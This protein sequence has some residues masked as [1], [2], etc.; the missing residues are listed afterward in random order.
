MQ[1]LEQ[2]RL[3]NITLYYREGTSDKV[4]QCSIEPAGERFVVNFAYG[5]RNS[6]LNTG[7]KTNVPVDYDHAR[8][9]FDKL[10]KEK[11]A[12]G[13]AKGESGTP[14]QAPD[15]IE[16]FTGILPQLLNSIDEVEM[17]RLLQNPAFVMQQKFDGRRMLIRKQDPEFHG[18]NKKGL[19][20][21]LP[22]TVAKDIQNLPG[23]FILD[24]ECIGDVF[25]AF[26]L[27][28]FNNKD[29]RP[30]PYHQ[31]LTAL[32]NLLASAQHRFIKYAMT[33]FTTW[34]KNRM[35]QELKAAKQEGVVFKRL[36]APYTPDRPNSGGP[37]L[38]RKFYATA[39]CVVAKINVQRS[40][41][42]RLLGQDGWLPC[43]NVTIPANHKIP[44]VGQVVEVRYLYAH[45]ESNA[46]YQP[47][48][49]GLRDDVAVG[50][51]LLTQ[52]KFKP[53]DEA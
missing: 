41:E 21:S 35:H 7:T 47:V 49:Q 28:T 1:T 24:G 48:Y 3:E 8:R 51:C 25:H 34:E 19:L 16:R 20:I 43:G 32:M 4:Y 33:A 26:D 13:Y 23:N 45:K 42:V 52:L 37:Q 10:V 2:P 53:E 5:R 11:Q 12:K 22:E 31:R 44:G 6:T 30:N 15:T 29:L 27:L 17:N 40:V 39:S 9:I 38:K 14:Y 50:E 46:L 18:I 36:N